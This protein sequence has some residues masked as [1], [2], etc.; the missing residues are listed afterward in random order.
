MQKEITIVQLNRSNFLHQGRSAS[1]KY[2]YCQVDLPILY[3]FYLNDIDSSPLLC[4]MKVDDQRRVLSRNLAYRTER[5]MKKDVFVVYSLPSFIS[6]EFHVQLFAL[7][8]HIQ[9]HVQWNSETAPTTSI[10]IL[11]SNIEIKVSWMAYIQLSSIKQ[12]DKTNMKWFVLALRHS[13]MI[14]LDQNRCLCFGLGGGECWAVQ[15]ILLF[16]G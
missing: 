1:N 4:L 9:I 8:E 3:M 13:L 15:R 14:C 12:S 11:I 2:Y 6:S 16:L 5:K 10:D 7:T